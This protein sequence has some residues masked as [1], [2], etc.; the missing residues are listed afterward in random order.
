MRLSL[1]D[2]VDASFCEAAAAAIAERLRHGAASADKPTVPMPGGWGS[3]YLDCRHRL[4]PTYLYGVP[5]AARAYVTLGLVGW[6]EPGR[7]AEDSDRRIDNVFGRWFVRHATAWVDRYPIVVQG[8]DLAS[9]VP[10]SLRWQLVMGAQRLLARKPGGED[11]PDVGWFYENAFE[12]CRQSTVTIGACPVADS[13]PRLA[14][15]LEEDARWVA[16]ELELMNPAARDPLLARLFLHVLHARLHVTPISGNAASR[17]FYKQLGEWLQGLAGSA[18]S[19]ACPSTEPAAW[20]SHHRTAVQLWPALGRLKLFGGTEDLDVQPRGRHLPAIF[21]PY[22]C[23][24]PLPL[25]AVLQRLDPPA[26]DAVAAAYLLGEMVA[27]QLIDLLNVRTT[28]SQRSGFTWQ[29][30]NKMG[31]RMDT[32]RSHYNVA[33]DDP[34]PAGEARLAV[35]QLFTE[36]GREDERTP[37]RV[38]ML[39]RAAIAGAGSGITGCRACLPVLPAQTG[40]AL[41]L[42]RRDV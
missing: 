6:V 40:P 9:A 25:D 22:A 13:G 24:E 37:R 19:D 34:L 20:S 38:E 2:S 32:T 17:P 11:L 3:L 15:L 31:R 23:A 35:R 4:C 26:R 18:G 5:P 8:R 16:C 21:R 29:A 42:W 33:R 36:L 27:N 12:R 41:P 1:P 39:L 30:Y 10:A 7:A 14:D 28:A